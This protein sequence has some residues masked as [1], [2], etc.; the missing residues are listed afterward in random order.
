[1][2]C[3]MRLLIEEAIC[4]HAAVRAASHHVRSDH[5]MTTPF[6]NR[7]VA[8]QPDCTGACHAFRCDWSNL[9]LLSLTHGA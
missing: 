9:D 8:M 5:E 1:M 4:V 2:Q 7:H 3:V 6:S